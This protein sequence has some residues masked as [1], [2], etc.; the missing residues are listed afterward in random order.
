MSSCG[1]TGR[2][3]DDSPLPS[4]IV[5]VTSKKSHTKL[6]SLMLYRSFHWLPALPG[7][8]TIV[9]S[10]I[11]IERLVVSSSRYAT[12]SLSN[13]IHNRRSQSS[14]LRRRLSKATSEISV[15]FASLART[16]VSQQRVTPRHMQQWH[17]QQHVRRWKLTQALD[18]T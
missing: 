11:R 16:T 4:P 2:R 1:S 6:G 17:T 7:S 15:Q 5:D 9:L 8:L 18:R 14:L 12:F 13:L 3:F 10:T